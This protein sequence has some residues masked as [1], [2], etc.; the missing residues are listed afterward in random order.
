MRS[1][2]SYHRAMGFPCC[3]WTA[4]FPPATLPL[5][6]SPLQ[7]LLRGCICWMVG[8]DF[9]GQ[10]TVFLLCNTPYVLSMPRQLF[11]SHVTH[12]GFS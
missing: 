10:S 11:D 2:C 1:P 3:S 8:W 6:F 4:P 12:L 9:C 7:V 5:W